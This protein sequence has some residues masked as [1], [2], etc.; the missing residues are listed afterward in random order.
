LDG[1]PQ[2]SSRTVIARI[3]ART[4]VRAGIGWGVVFGLYVATQALTYATTY[5]TLASRLVLATQFGHNVGIS[6]LVG[7]A[8]RIDT[9]PG[10]TAW[11]CLTV[12]A[13]MGAVWGVLA[14]TKLTRGEEDAGRW[15]LLLAG[16]VTRRSAAQQALVGMGAGAAALFVSSAVFFIVVGRSSKVDIGVGAALYFSL[17]VACGALMFLAVGAICGQLST[18]RRQAIGFASAILGASYAIR[19]IADSGSGLSWLRWITPLGWIEELQP[20]TSPRSLALLPI[21]AFVVVLGVGTLF[22]AGRRDLGA[23]TF[24]DRSS[25][26]N[27][28]RLPTR[29]FGLAVFLSRGTLLAWAGSIVA[30][31]LLLGSIAKSGGEMITASRSLRNVFARLGISGAEAYLSVAFLLMAVTLSFVAV[32]QVNAARKEE[33]GGQLEN[34]LVRPLSRTSWLAQRIG[35]ATVVIVLGGALAGVSTWVG[36]VSDHADVRFLSLLDAGLNVAVP[37]LLIFGVGVL[38]LGVVPRMVSLVTYAVLVWFLLVEILGSAVT[39]NHWILD[40]SG[41]HQMAAAP[42]TPVDWTSNAVMVAL[43]VAAASLGVAVFDRR[44]VKDE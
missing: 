24:P 19:M 15:E 36:A 42:A 43:A 29:P 39:A 10:F 21:A 40:L 7:P 13:I 22:L 25:I 20:L 14:S 1:T 38:A 31:G 11:K 3:T 33:S 9:V 18:S 5:K 17:A 28:R 35:L 6:A 2:S 26:A 44:D 27:A 12:L 41:Y 34:L 23:G 32:G 4:S 8:I 30:Y 16:Q 37:S